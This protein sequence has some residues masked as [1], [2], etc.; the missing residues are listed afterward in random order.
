MNIKK[1]SSSAHNP[2]IRVPKI[3]DDIQSSKIWALKS[4][5]EQQKDTLSRYSTKKA[6][7]LLQVF[8]DPSRS[9]PQTG[10]PIHTITP[11]LAESQRL[12]ATCDTFLELKKA[13]KIRKV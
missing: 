1:P 10:E 6:S 7:P 3:Q 8:A 5:R 11:F 9:K 4:R 12:C 2:D 13:F